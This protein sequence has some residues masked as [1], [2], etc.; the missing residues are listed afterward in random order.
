MEKRS[1]TSMMRVSIFNMY[2]ASAHDIIKGGIVTCY[3]NDERY[4][5]RMDRGDG[6]F[7]V[8]MVR[9]ECIFAT[10]EEA[11]MA[12]HAFIRGRLLI[13][14][15]RMNLGLTLILGRSQFR[16]APFLYFFLVLR[17]ILL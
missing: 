13:R 11:F 15:R 6:T 9:S 8:R 14:S 7:V 17:P 2:P 3:V 4:K 16:F 1:I 5:V 12:G 10:K